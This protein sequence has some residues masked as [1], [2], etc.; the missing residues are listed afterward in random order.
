MKKFFIGFAI[1]ILLA[2]PYFLPM[3]IATSGFIAQYALGEPMTF[4]IALWNVSPLAREITSDNATQVVLKVDG[5]PIATTAT[6][7]SPRVAQFS[8]VEQT[9]SYQI[10]KKSVDT[11]RFDIATNTIELPQ[12][13]HDISVEWLGS[14]SFSHSIAIVQ[15]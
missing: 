15:M 9:V 6:S 12:G 2:S 4:D 8:R 7:V 10:S 11:A 14:S 1:L 5:K 13:R 3:P